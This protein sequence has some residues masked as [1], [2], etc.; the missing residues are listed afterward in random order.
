MHRTLKKQPAFRE[1]LKALH[2]YCSDSFRTTVRTEFVLEAQV[3]N[4]NSRN[5][6][7]SGLCSNSRTLNMSLKS[8]WVF[9]NTKTYRIPCGMGRVEDENTFS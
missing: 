1:K 6:S 5:I 2:K 3:Q 9:G 8:E 7:N 4:N